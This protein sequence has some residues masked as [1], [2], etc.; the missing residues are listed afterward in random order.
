MLTRLQLKLLLKPVEGNEAQQESIA[1]SEVKDVADK[2]E[3][4]DRKEAL[5]TEGISG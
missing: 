2:K 3:V 4:A 5:D 1:Q